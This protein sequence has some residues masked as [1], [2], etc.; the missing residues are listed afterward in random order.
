MSYTPARDF[1]ALLN[2]LKRPDAFPFALPPDTEISL[3]QTH[4]SAVLLTPRYVYKL[5]KPLN[6]GFFDYSTPARR[7]HFCGQEVLLNTRLAP[8]IYLG[9][10]PVL[11]FA[12]QIIRFG[13]MLQPASV[14]EPGSMFDGGE[15]ID[16]AVVMV[17]LPDEATLEAHIHAG[18]ATP[19]LLAEV[20]RVVAAFHDTA[21]TD[22]HIASFGGLDVIRGN[23]EENF[24][25]MKPYIGRCISAAAYERIA[26]YI[27]RFMDARAS[28]FTE[29][30]RNGRIRDCHGDLRLQHVYFLA[31]VKVPDHPLPPL[32]VLDCIEFNERFRYSDVAAEIAFLTMELDAIGRNDLSQVFIDRYIAATGD[33]ALRELLPFYACYRACVR[34]K[35][36][37]FQ[38]EEPE[39][40]ELQR[41]RVRQ[42]ASMLFDLAA[43][44][45]S[46]PTTPTVLIV[47]GLM[48][49]GKSTLAR[50]LQ[51]QLGWALF[52]SD[53]M[54]KQLAGL[55]PE[56]PS[57]D[58]FGKGLY[59]AEWTAR[60]YAA[61]RAEVASALSTGRSALLDASFLRR[62]ERQA[63]VQIAAAHNAQVIFVECTCPREVVL[64]RLA[65][66]WEQRVQ[67]KRTSCAGSAQASDGRPELYDK[68]R[69]NWEELDASEKAVMQQ[70][71]LATT[72]PLAVNIEQVLDCL[73]M[74]RLT[75]F[76][77]PTR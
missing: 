65:R 60:T 55:E 35:V 38:L 17:R 27:R 56:Q 34:G 6:F 68:Q 22:E 32:A 15:V 8:Q 12:P 43:S 75:C 37:S 29:R 41:E 3:V 18:S 73:Q 66:R 57:A 67:G 59:S 16:Y 44:Y 61:L 63:L 77:G 7:R 25:Q 20:A 5:K 40:P 52:S 30:I 11:A 70:Y 50:A 49:T 33:A 42:E 54:R 58:E 76:I 51:R 24:A 2:A 36:S 64:Q 1:A 9:V 19:T 21:R 13:P 39:I 72:R 31:Q 47:G 28:L 48:G 62:A 53:T 46:G 69:A 4:A 74:P 45:A 23:W 10:A 71:V 26:T 14:P